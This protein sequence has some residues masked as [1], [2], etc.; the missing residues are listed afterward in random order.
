MWFANKNLQVAWLYFFR[1]LLELLEYIII[2]D[3]D[4]YENEKTFSKENISPYY[5]GFYLFRYQLYRTNNNPAEAREKALAEV[6]YLAEKK[7]IE[8]ELCNGKKI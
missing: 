6:Q 4:E 5:R 8:K 3:L 7:Y 1:R 2:K